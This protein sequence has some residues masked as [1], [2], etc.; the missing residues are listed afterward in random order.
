[1]LNEEPDVVYMS[2]MHVIL[3]LSDE[4]IVHIRSDEG[5]YNKITYDC[6]FQKNVVA[7]ILTKNRDLLKYND[8]TNNNKKHKYFIS[9]VTD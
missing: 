4:R 9:F 6:Y 5:K 8:L 7:M 3:Y 1:M 2:K